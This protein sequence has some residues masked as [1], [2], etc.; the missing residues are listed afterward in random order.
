MLQSSYTCPRE[1]L[2]VTIF[3]D[4]RPQRTSVFTETHGQYL[5]ALPMSACPLS[6]VVGIGFSDDVID[7]K[8][9]EKEP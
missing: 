3:P 5:T 4:V 7:S 8:S 6:P 2:F 9:I 1:G